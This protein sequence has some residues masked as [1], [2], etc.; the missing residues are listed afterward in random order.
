M[1]R[2]TTMDSGKELHLKREGIILT[3]EE[4]KQV[5]HF[6]YSDTRK[7]A[8]AA[9]AKAAWAIL[10]YIHHMALSESG[11]GSEEFKRGFAQ[12]MAF[13]DLSLLGKLCGLGIERPEQIC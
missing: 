3:G 4:L 10:S 1:S 7:I 12:G 8:D 2:D 5:A 13:L 11:E 6:I 9:T